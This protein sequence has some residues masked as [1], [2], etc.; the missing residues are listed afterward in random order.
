MKQHAFLMYTTHVG[1]KPLQ[2]FSAIHNLAD[3][4][5]ARC[6]VFVS[7]MVRCV[8]QQL[9]YLGY[10]KFVTISYVTCQLLWIPTT[11]WA[12]CAMMLTQPK[13]VWIMV[14]LHWHWSKCAAARQAL[15][16]SIRSIG[17]NSVYLQHQTSLVTE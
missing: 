1:I 12:D 3:F 8:H 9:M 5:V 11:Q 14:E 6:T 10:R 15:G 7:V 16:R 2:S 13:E 17:Q 4:S